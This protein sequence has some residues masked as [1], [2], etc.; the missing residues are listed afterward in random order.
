MARYIHIYVK[1][2]LFMVLQYHHLQTADLI[3]R[4]KMLEIVSIKRQ[5]SVRFQNWIRLIWTWRLK[6]GNNN[7][8]MVTFKLMVTCRSQRS[9]WHGMWRDKGLIFKFL[10]I[11]LFMSVFCVSQTESHP[12]NNWFYKMRFTM[13]SLSILPHL[14]FKGS[15]TSLKTK[16]NSMVKV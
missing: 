1:I 16:N 14:F 12:L 5:L 11:N 15:Q 10:Q 6:N 2:E 4:L 3:I 8:Q 7:N 9:N 13:L